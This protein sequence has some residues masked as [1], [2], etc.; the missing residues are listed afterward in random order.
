MAFNESEPRATINELNV[1]VNDIAQ[2]TA[3]VRLRVLLNQS[4]AE[5][6]VERLHRHE[7]EIMQVLLSVATYASTLKF[8]Q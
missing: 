3:W 7:E 8:V 6:F 1:F 4:A 5:K 2:R